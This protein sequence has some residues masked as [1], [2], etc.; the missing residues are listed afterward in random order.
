ADVADKLT[1]PLKRVAQLAELLDKFGDRGDAA[2]TKV[3]LAR[4]KQE[5]DGVRKLT[6][7][8]PGAAAAVRMANNTHCP[9]SG[10]LVGS[11]EPG[12]HIDIEGVRIGLCCMGCEGEFMKDPAANVKKA[13][14]LAQTKTP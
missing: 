1:A 4:F 3:A 8:A 10:Q 9:I 7:S 11:M 2:Q 13:L 5:I 14:L 6:G 12:S